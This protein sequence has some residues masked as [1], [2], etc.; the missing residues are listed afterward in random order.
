VIDQFHSESTFQDTSHTF[1]IFYE[2]FGHSVPDPGLVR[3][4]VVDIGIDRIAGA[5]NRFTVRI[6]LADHTTF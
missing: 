3:L 5:G 4:G 6:D 2:D 1:A